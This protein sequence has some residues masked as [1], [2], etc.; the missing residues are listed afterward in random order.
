MRWIVMSDE[1]YDEV[2]KMQEEMD[3]MFARYF[4]TP[5]KNRYV[6]PAR[7]RGSGAPVQKV[8][9][10]VSDIYETESNIVA[11]FEL[12]GIDKKDIELNVTEQAVEVKVK[13][14]HEK[15]VN[16]QGFYRYESGSRS[17]YRALPLPS[18]VMP[19]KVQAEYKEGVLKVEM[20]KQKSKEQKKKKIE[21]S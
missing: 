1:P 12:P 6:V 2:R 20:P 16:K 10:A 15:E 9:R 11:M 18:K 4:G 19:E 5:S 14:K 3:R 17:F 7:A 21:I 13:K 8:R